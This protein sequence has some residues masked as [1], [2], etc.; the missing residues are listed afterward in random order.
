[1]ALITAQYSKNLETI[2]QFID[3][4]Q[5]NFWLIGKNTFTINYLK[6]NPWLMQFQPEVSRAIEMMTKKEKSIT[7]QLSNRCQ[8]FTEQNLGAIKAKCITSL[9]EKKTE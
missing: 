1:M 5:I 2:R 9:A 3:K 7:A 4:Y 8:I 6:N